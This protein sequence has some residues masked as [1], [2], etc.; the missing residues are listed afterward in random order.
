MTTPEILNL[1]KKKIADSHNWTQG[2]A[3]R[4]MFGDAVSVTSKDAV[5]WCAVGSLQSLSLSETENGIGAIA[6]LY[7]D[8]AS[9]IHITN[10]GDL[11]SSAQFND[12]HSHEE[13]MKLFDKAIELAKREANA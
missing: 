7:L 9:G 13:V 8:K 11:R 1:A 5:C 3:A 10:Y 12:T 4:D 6:C 2:T